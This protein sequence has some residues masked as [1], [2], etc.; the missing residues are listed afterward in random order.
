MKPED[1]LFTTEDQLKL[2]FNAYNFTCSMNLQ[3]SVG[4]IRKVYFTTILLNVS[5]T[6]VQEDYP[7][8][9]KV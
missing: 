6:I 3:L 8:T 1:Q 5:E 9:M 2:I 4:T 7:S